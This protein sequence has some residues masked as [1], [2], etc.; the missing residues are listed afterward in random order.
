VLGNYFC[1]LGPERIQGNKINPVF[2]IN[3]PDRSRD[4][5]YCRSTPG[6]FS[7]DR[8]VYAIQDLEVI[9]TR[10]ELDEI[11][12][13][14]HLIVESGYGDRFGYALSREAKQYMPEDLL[15]RNISEALALNMARYFKNPRNAR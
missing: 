9:L 6:E 1:T 15:A 11:T 5:V 10:K 12:G 4:M 7:V 8:M 13:M 3:K 2:R 14:T